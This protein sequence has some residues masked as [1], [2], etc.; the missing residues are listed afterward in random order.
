MSVEVQ[1]ITTDGGVL[2]FTLQN[3]NVSLANALRRCILSDIPVIVMKASPYKSKTIDI[4]VNK[5]RF[6]NEMIEHRISCI[7]V[8]LDIDSELNYKNYKIQLH[9]INTTNTIMHVTTQ[10]IEI[11]DQQSDTSVSKKIVEKLF[12]KNDIT[13]DYIEIIRLRPQTSIKQAEEIK[14]SATFD[15]STA[16]NNAVYN[17]TSI[18]S[19]GKT[20]NEELAD[21]ERL[22]LQKQLSSQALS[23]ELIQEKLSDFDN[24]TKQR[25]TIDDS[26]DFIIETIGQYT[27]EQLVAKACTIL[28]NNLKQLFTELNDNPDLITESNTTLDNGYDIKLIKQ[29]YTL[30]K[31]LEYILYK[32]YYG[33][34]KT[35]RLHFCGFRKPHPHIDE[36]IIRLGFRKPVEK[37]DIIRMFQE[38]VNILNTIYSDLATEFATSS[39]I[40]TTSSSSKTS[41]SAN[42]VSTSTDSV[43]DEPSQSA[44]AEPAEPILVSTDLP[45]LTELSK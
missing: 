34:K 26:F 1:N 39:V 24:L 23:Q 4:L 30:G 35:D 32:T 21:I 40:E 16:K 18:C 9:E 5:S 45:E 27:N 31:I 8:M 22:K 42:L 6:T 20:I 33:I 28:I 12:P 15:I 38:A 25:I 7:P 43:K 36:S 3:I 19:Y 44:P 37:L 29:D 2:K 13:Q 10:S 17:A 11:V 41:D 14:L